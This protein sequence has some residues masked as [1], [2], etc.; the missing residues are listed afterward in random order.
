MPPQPPSFG[1]QQ[2]W[3]ARFTSNSNPF[4]WLEAPNA[5]D[6]FLVEAL[7][8]TLDEN[9][10]ILHV[11]CGTSLLSYH[12]RAHVKDPET[13]HNLDYSDVAIGIGKK[14]ECELYNTEVFE[15][16]VD[17]IDGSNDTSTSDKDLKGESK[18]ESSSQD[19]PQLA[20]TQ[21]TPTDETGTAAARKYMRWSAANL[22]SHS[23]L[24]EVCKP[25]AY[26]VIV[27]KSTSDSVAC[28]EDV[29]VPLPYPV[30]VASTGPISSR[31]SESPEPIHPLHILA[32]HMALLTKPRARWISLS[33]SEDRYPFLHQ[34]MPPPLQ[35]VT[36]ATTSQ[37]PT[38][39]LTSREDGVSDDGSDDELELDD[40]LDDI[41]QSVIDSGLPDPGTLWRLEAK[42]EIE[43]P[44]QISPN[45]TT[46][47]AHLPKILHWVYILQRT[48]VK[49]SVRDSR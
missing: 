45:S 15:K 42:H 33:Y 2:Y 11:G 9:P 23:S 48:D 34:Q 19:E 17:K 31:I 5:L 37:L 6:S 46:N 26:S 1:S 36:T 30:G 25:S 4:E 20:P 18:A 10:H 32:I 16:A 22:L 49:V 24:L 12:L 40:D 38:P 8:E 47:P 7:R 28:S 29:K 41:P 13:I 27:D 43:V 39:A 35:R 21:S 44:P 3:D 14:R